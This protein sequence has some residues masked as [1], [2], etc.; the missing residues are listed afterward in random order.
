ARA[1]AAVI[2][3]SRA[4][5]ASDAA[6]GGSA[7][8]MPAEAVDM[9]NRYLA[10]EREFLQAIAMKVQ[11]HIEAVKEDARAARRMAQTPGATGDETLPPDA[12]QTGDGDAGS[13][14]AA[15]GVWPATE[16]EASAPDPGGGTAEPRDPGGVDGPTE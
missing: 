10:R 3:A 13:D 11:D 16:A 9:V 6:G 12:D 5:G 8:A 1:R 14:D 2:G 7:A 4:S 15:T